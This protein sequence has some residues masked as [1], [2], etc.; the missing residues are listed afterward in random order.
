VKRMISSLSDLAIRTSRTIAIASASSIA[1]CAVTACM[2]SS[3]EEALR[4]S[5]DKLETKV[6]ALEKELAVRDEK[7]KTIGSKTAAGESA[8]AGLEEVKR[9]ISMTQG[10][11]DELRVK[12]SRIG[13]AGT[14][15]GNAGSVT[16]ESDVGENHDKLA[17]LERRI[18]KLEQGQPGAKGAAKGEAKGGAA[19]PNPKYASAKELA[20]VLGGH[21]S[22]KEY[23][24]VESLSSE[25]LASGL[26]ADYKETA[27]MFKAEAAFSSEN[28]KASAADFSEFLRKYPTSDRRPRALLLAGDSHVYLKQLDTAKVQYKEC[29][30]KFAKKQECVAAKERLERLGN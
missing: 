26:G 24:K 1:L 30:D 20:K 9:Q 25:V 5:I 13:E 17:D 14:A 16:T 8:S 12:L 29:V 15:E 28:Y 6:A 23:A 11:V 27:L 18:A 3:R 4:S 21:F 22:K 19:K 7:I 10:A 2:S